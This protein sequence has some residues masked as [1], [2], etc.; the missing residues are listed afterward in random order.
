MAA[1]LAAIENEVAARILRTLMSLN[2]GAVITSYAVMYH[3]ALW[4]AAK[5]PLCASEVATWRV[6]GCFNYNHV[7]V[8][9]HHRSVKVHQQ[10]QP[11]SCKMLDRGL[12]QHSLI[13]PAA[14]FAYWLAIENVPH[15]SAHLHVFK[16]GYPAASLFWEDFW[17]H[18]VLIFLNNW[19]LHSMF[20]LKRLTCIKAL[21][22]QFS[23]EM[24]LQ[25]PHMHAQF[26]YQWLWF[27]IVRATLPIPTKD[28]SY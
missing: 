11:N 22:M 17:S 25:E 15:T 7:N 28:C 9:I 27:A 13:T 10:Q 24:Q 12:T 5:V 20:L 3:L 14:S 8:C 26:M 19:K 18:S 1:W 16:C 21:G 23:E 2:W 4:L 6:A